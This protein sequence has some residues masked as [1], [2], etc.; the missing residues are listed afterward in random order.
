[1]Q[2]FYLTIS[3]AAC[4]FLPFFLPQNYF[5]EEYFI[6]FIYSMQCNDALYY[7]YYFFVNEVFSLLFSS[8]K[9]KKHKAALPRLYN[10]NIL[11]EPSNEKVAEAPHARILCSLL[12]C[13]SEK[14]SLFLPLT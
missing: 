10:L 5:L 14:G 4:I 8:K 6:L 7:Y 2:E 12:P 1:M 3:R 11:F 9:R 13:F